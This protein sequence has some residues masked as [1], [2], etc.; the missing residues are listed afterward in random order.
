MSIFYPTL[1]KNKITDITVDDLKALGVEGLLLDVDN[2]L[3]RHKVPDVSD[4]VR[5][6]LQTMRDA[7][8][9]MTV[10][11]NGFASRV[12]PV[13]EKIGLQ[14]VALSCKPSPIGFW[15]GARRLHLPLKKCCAIG[16]QVF[17]D[18]L[19]AHLAHVKIIQVIPYALEYGYHTVMFRRHFEKG[20][21]RR[22]QKKY[23][24]PK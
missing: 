16:D 7:G 18:V 21:V 1:M 22:Y 9:A 4:E 24:V 10:V 12:L 11:S 14:A 17:T 3:A 19:G 13:T 8:I 5:A 20:I 6:W 23:G 15:R 2:T